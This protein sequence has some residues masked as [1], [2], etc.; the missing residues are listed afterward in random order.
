MKSFKHRLPLILLLGKVLIVTLAVAAHAQPAHAQELK[1][2]FHQGV[3]ICA[4]QFYYTPVQ[5]LQLN[6]LKQEKN[7]S[8]EAR[9][10]SYLKILTPAQQQQLGQ[11]I[12]TEVEHSAVSH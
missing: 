11:C 5:L 4:K 10:Q 12:K 2:D 1:Q 9:F 6:H 8:Q 3:S 7:L